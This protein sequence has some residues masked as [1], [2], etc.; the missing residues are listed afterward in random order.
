MAA[1]DFLNDFRCHLYSSCM[2][3]QGEGEEVAKAMS[4]ETKENVQ[5]CTEDGRKSGGRWSIA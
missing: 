1:P 4:K 3:Y 2:I 5:R